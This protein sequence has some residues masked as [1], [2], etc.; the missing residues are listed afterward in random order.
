MR[1]RIVVFGVVAGA[2]A[3]GIGRSF[4]EPAAR[5]SAERAAP[6]ESAPPP[7]ETAPATPSQNPRDESD[8]V[9]EFAHEKGLP[10]AIVHEALAA[11]YD[12]SAR[13]EF[14]RRGDAAFAAALA[15]VRGG[16]LHEGLVD[17]LRRTW[18]PGLEDELLALGG[19]PKWSAEGRAA[20]VRALGVADTDAVRAFLA[21]ESERARHNATLFAAVAASQAELGTPGLAKRIAKNLYR[22]GWS[23]FRPRLLDALGADGSAEA[24][25]VLLDH[26]RKPRPPFRAY[27]ERAARALDRIEP[28]AGRRAAEKLLAAGPAELTETDRTAL[29]RYLA[30]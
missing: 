18:R 25:R 5:R 29:R 1:L 4:R 11:R 22:A 24:R 6:A 9:A 20:I 15:L 23:N 8:R 26:L 17:V 27:A 10:P 7:A 21:Q 12:E 16:D 30:E 19:N 2:A 3:F 28:G 14:V 13:E